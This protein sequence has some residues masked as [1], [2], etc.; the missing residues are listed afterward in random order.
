MRILSV[1]GAFIFAS[2]ASPAAAEAFTMPP[3]EIAGGDTRVAL[4][5]ELIEVL[6][7]LG[8]GVEL[9]GPGSTAVDGNPNFDITG[10]FLNLNTVTGSIEHVASGIRLFDG[11][12]RLLLCDEGARGAAPAKLSDA[13]KGP[14]AILIGPEGGFSE[15]ERQRLRALPFATP[16]ALGPRILRAETAALAALTLWQATLGD[17]T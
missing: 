16:T 6:D 11:A 5:P 10:G 15:A 12:R 3:F 17:W 7:G 9:V 1:I 13:D 8:V 4:N 14:W 2:A